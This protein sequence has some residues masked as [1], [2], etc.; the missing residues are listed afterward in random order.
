MSR[1]TTSS[2]I[3]PRRTACGLLAIVVLGFAGGC[4]WA[5]GAAVLPAT[6]PPTASGLELEVGEPAAPALAK[7]PPPGMPDAV[8]A[9][10]PAVAPAAVYVTTERDLGRRVEVVGVLDFHSNA[11]SEDKGFDELRAKAAA[12]GADAVVAAEFEHADASGR[13]HLSGMA[14]RLR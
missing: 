9:A 11:A 12:L 10:M 3:A 5:T 1:R 2:R 14:V 7:T 4:A 8:G 6:Q 13:S